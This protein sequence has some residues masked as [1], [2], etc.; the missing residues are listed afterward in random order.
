MKKYRTLLYTAIAT[1]ICYNTPHEARADDDLSYLYFFSSAT[2]PLRSFSVNDICKLTFEN[3][4]LNVVHTDGYSISLAYETFTKLTFESQ[5]FVSSIEERIT[6]SENDVFVRYSPNQICI[7]C[8]DQLKRLDLYDIQGKKVALGE[9]NGNTGT[10]NISSLPTG[11][12]IIYATNDFKK[13]S[14]KFIKP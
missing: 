3:E 7:E 1:T 14:I 6:S 4:N 12:Y 10:I 11:I 2:Q 8:T 5:P 13:H 9:I